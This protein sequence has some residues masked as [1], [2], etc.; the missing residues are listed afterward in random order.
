MTSNFRALLWCAAGAV[1]FA[2]VVI[3][4]DQQKEKSPHKERL[5]S[6]GAISGTISKLADDKGSFTLKVSG[7]VPY[8]RPSVSF[9]AGRKPS[10][11]ASL[12]QKKVSQEFDVQLTDD[13]RIRR[14]DSG[15]QKDCA[16]EDLRKGQVVQ[17]TLLRNRHGD[18]FAK[19]ILIVDEPRPS[20]T[21][22][23]SKPGQ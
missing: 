18:L 2:S 12:R 3:A 9:A 20:A 22:E 4:Q 13:V 23:E 19:A 17:V 15:K 6:V 8:L 16:A 7:E 5:T 11:S 10:V 14:R 21:S 1:I